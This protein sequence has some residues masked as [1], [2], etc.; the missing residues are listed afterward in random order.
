[1]WHLITAIVRPHQLDAVKNALREA[2]ATGLTVGEARGYGRQGGHAETYR[3]AEYEVDFL[4]KIKVEVLVDTF[5]AERVA[6]ALSA[7][8]RTGDIGDG[9]VWIT[10]IDQATRIRT[11]ELGPDAV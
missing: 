2:G 9:K 8:A 1:M 11:G 3:G 5:D 4:P 7:A 6:G 10:A